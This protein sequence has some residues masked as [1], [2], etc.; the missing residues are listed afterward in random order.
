MKDRCEIC[1][2]ECEVTKH[3]LVPA[4]ETKN[5]YKKLKNDEGNFI[6]ICRLCHDQI[7]ALFQINELRDVYNTKEALLSNEKFAKFV[8]WRKKHPE[9][10][11][12]SKM[13]KELKL[14]TRR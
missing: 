7:H 14:K 8:E 1:G 12:H 11:G 2:T 5:K 4:S 10:D 6:W 3:H 13:S 9:Y